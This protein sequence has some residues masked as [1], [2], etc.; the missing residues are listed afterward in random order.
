MVPQSNLRS[1]TS[2]PMDLPG[3]IASVFVL[4]SS[5]VNHGCDKLRGDP[6]IELSGQ[7]PSVFGNAVKSSRLAPTTRRTTT[8]RASPMSPGAV[9]PAGRQDVISKAAAGTGRMFG[10]CILRYAPSAARTPQ[11]R[12]CPGETVRSTVATASGAGPVRARRGVTRRES[13]PLERA[14]N[15][16]AYDPRKRPRRRKRS[17]ST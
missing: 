6:H 14:L 9:S 2:F 17:I 13:P 1:L 11:C 8:R 3:R 12:S 5:D 15:C 16:R 4:P 10:K 7:N